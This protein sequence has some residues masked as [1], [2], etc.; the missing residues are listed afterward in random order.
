M[1][2]LRRNKGGATVTPCRRFVSFIQNNPTLKRQCKRDCKNSLPG[3]VIGENLNLSSSTF[4][5][6]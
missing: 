6:H 4:K 1:T 5:A 3:S 2:G